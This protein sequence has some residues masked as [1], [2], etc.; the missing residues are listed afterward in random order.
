[1]LDDDT[2]YESFS[3]TGNGNLMDSK[4]LRPS[5]IG[6]SRIERNTTV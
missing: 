5:S 2:E 6:C 3:I 1:M 4:V